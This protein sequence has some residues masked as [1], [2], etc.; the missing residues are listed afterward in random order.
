MRSSRASRM[1]RAPLTWR[2]GWAIMIAVLSSGCGL[3]PGCTSAGPASRS[4][5]QP[6]DVAHLPPRER[7]ATLAAW[8]GRTGG[9][10]I[11]VGPPPGVDPAHL[12]G[13][14]PDDP[15]AFL[16]EQDAVASFQL[17]YPRS[18]TDPSPVVEPGAGDDDLTRR[19]QAQ[20]HYVRGLQAAVEGRHFVAVQDFEQALELDPTS[21]PALRQAARSYA[22]TRN[23]ARA[24]A[25][26]ERLIR[27]QP[28]DREAALM[29]GLNMANQRRYAEVIHA[30][31]PIRSRREDGAPASFGLDSAADVLADQA[32]A[33]AFEHFGYDAAAA[34][35]LQRAAIGIDTFTGQSGYAATIASLARARADRYRLLGDLFCRLNRLDE[36]DVAYSISAADG[37]VP[38]AVLTPRRLFVA[39]RRGRPHAAQLLLLEALDASQWRAEENLIQWASWLRSATSD[40]SPLAECAKEALGAAPQEAPAARLLA[41]M[42]PPAEGVAMLRMV[43]ERNPDDQATLDD[44]LRWLA[45]DAAEQA[46]V[47]VA[48]LVQ[49][50]PAR[51][52]RYSERLFAAIGLPDDRTWSLIADGRPAGAMNFLRAR[53]FLQAG[54]PAEAWRVADAGL[55]GSS[56]DLLLPLVRVQAAA[57]MREPELLEQAIRESEAIHELARSAATR[58]TGQAETSQPPSPPLTLQLHL[59]ICSALREI[60]RSADAAARA[61]ETVARWPESVDAWVERAR[62]ELAAPGRAADAETSARTAL[63]L[64]PACEPAHEL[65]LSLYASTGPLA[66]QSR[67]QQ[68]WD[69]LSRAAP[70]GRLAAIITADRLLG[71]RR[72]SQAVDTLVSWFQRDPGDEE[73]L[74]RLVSAHLENDQAVNARRWLEGRLDERPDDPR[75]LRQW[76]RVMLSQ[77]EYAAAETRLISRREGWP[78][79]PVAPALLEVVWRAQGRLAEAEE[80]A[81]QRLA[82]RPDGVQKT[83][84]LASLEVS[85]GRW[86][87][88]IECLAPLRRRFD[89][90]P[91]E[92]TAGLLAIAA[93]LPHEGPESEQA[94]LAIVEQF[95]DRWPDAPLSVYAPALLA[96]ARVDEGGEAF[97]SM[98]LRG[99]R[100]TSA[101]APE[102]AAVIAWRDVAQVLL[103]DERPLAA[104][105]VAM[106]RLNATPE[107]ERAGLALLAQVAQAC[108]IR[109]G[110]VD[111]A[112]GVIDDLASREMLDILPL[113]RELG[114]LRAEAY[115]WLSVLATQIG[116]QDA[117]ED[118]LRR[119]LAMVPDNPT[120]LNNLGYHRID[121]NHDDEESVQMVERAFQRASDD[122]NILDTVGWL[123]YKQGRFDW[124]QQGDGARG[125]IERSISATRAQRREPSAEAYDHLGDVY[126]RLGDRG[127]AVEAWDIAARIVND[128]ERRTTT[129]Q[130]LRG[131][132][133]NV[134]GVELVRSESLYDLHDGKVGQ[135][136][137]EKSRAARAG[138]EPPVAPTFDE[139]RAER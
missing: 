80:L 7:L 85:A 132:Q 56:T 103:D 47:F 120:A 33:L 44:L 97:E 114:N 17:L 42:L 79:D 26:Y 87:D 89:A 102:V 107:P 38:P 13:R 16:E 5:V 76:V 106:I 133:R 29:V 55:R 96:L 123:R 32:L 131:Y 135:R 39:V 93:Q 54:A 11:D 65:L 31:G 49:A 35:F 27:L 6:P 109:A 95:L 116:Q 22:A 34:A 48:T 40:V 94:R 66:D 92:T 138:Q 90:L 126:W 139:A 19:I 72:A 128:A 69:D 53:L 117:A 46:A 73:V 62:C 57:A 112:R 99:I 20:I 24:N 124:D 58:P 25:M 21:A 2:A 4:T 129:I 52:F 83:L 121:A 84:E 59:I 115:Y 75:L 122:P 51:G 1:D 36:A 81:R 113:P 100:Q 8:E 78:G 12:V 86:R 110:R 30:L 43:V 127:R 64:D 111:D 9:P 28:D 50:D 61:A 119:S 60:G 18:E 71:A 77:R 98:V 137:A 67:L 105:R 134:W 125:L 101:G 88:A 3:N 41:A 10:A 74:T 70:G 118:L 108:F 104:A 14:A 45:R 37:A 91:R 63:T 82:R 136:A 23:S 130:G 68:Q 15:R